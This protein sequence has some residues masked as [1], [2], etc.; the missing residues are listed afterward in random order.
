M[1]GALLAA[2]LLMTWRLMASSFQMRN[3]PGVL[4]GF[5]FGCFVLFLKQ[6]MKMY[7]F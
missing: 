6:I 5:M 7:N 3:F 2:G 4:Q 1:D